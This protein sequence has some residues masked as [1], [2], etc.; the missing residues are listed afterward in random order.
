MTSNGEAPSPSVPSMHQMAQPEI[1][2]TAEYMARQHPAF[3]RIKNI[4]KKHLSK[5]AANASK[6]AGK[7]KL[8]SAR[9]AK[10][11]KGKASV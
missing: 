7:L 10:T 5:G 8:R 3:N 6:A 11:R 4:V 9:S 2:S 1:D